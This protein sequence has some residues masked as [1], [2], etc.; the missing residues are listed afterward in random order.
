MCSEIPQLCSNW[1]PCGPPPT[2]A[3]EHTCTRL[4]LIGVHTY[5]RTRGG[6]SRPCGGY[7]TYK[8]LPAGGQRHSLCMIGGHPTRLLVPSEHTRAPCSLARLASCVSHMPSGSGWGV[9]HVWVLPPLP[10]QESPGTP[11]PSGFP[12]RSFPVGFFLGPSRLFVSLQAFDAPMSGETLNAEEVSNRNTVAA[13]Y[14]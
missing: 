11:C 4:L 3:P 10:V 13:A 6:L 2:R 1:S 14:C 8:G 7:Q 9:T 12:S 5:T